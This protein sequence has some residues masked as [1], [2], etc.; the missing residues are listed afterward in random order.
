MEE[1]YKQEI[2]ELTDLLNNDEEWEDTKNILL[3]SGIHL[4]ETIL[5]SFMEDDEENE[6]GVIVSKNLKISKYSRNT[7]ESKKNVENFEIVDITDNEEEIN[8]HPQI[9]IAIDMIKNG[10]IL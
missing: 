8:K 6:Y 1:L 7:R 2:M 5:V 9:T 3:Q 4:K 10:E